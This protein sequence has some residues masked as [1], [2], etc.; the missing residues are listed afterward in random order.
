MNRH[1][2]VV[3]ED[4]AVP[5]STRI[6]SPAVKVLFVVRLTVPIVLEALNR[7]DLFVPSYSWT[8]NVP[9]GTSQRAMVTVRAAAAGAKYTVVVPVIAVE[10]A[11]ENP[12]V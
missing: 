9:V 10:D 8:F 6:L 7:F 12:V 3:G 4:E 11:H 1:A 5:K 2:I